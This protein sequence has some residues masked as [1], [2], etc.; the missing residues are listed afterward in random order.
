MAAWNAATYVAQIDEER[1]AS[2][3]ASGVYVEATEAVMHRHEGV[4]F[5]DEAFVVTRRAG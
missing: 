2:A 1:L 4:W 3:M 5:N